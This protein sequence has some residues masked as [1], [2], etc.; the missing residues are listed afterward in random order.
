MGILISK[1]YSPSL[2]TTPGKMIT[3]RV[4]PEKPGPQCHAAIA[5]THRI[6]QV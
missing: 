6:T 3:Q 1:I 2:L 5:I 4:H